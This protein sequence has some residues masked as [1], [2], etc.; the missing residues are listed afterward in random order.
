MS[1]PIEERLFIQMDYPFN[2]P[3]KECVYSLNGE[4]RHGILTNFTVDNGKHG[5]S[6]LLVI[7]RIYP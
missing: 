5:A 2:N 3:N 6:I 4:S 1:E 7:N